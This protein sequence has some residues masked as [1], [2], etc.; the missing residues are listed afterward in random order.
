MHR[1]LC[2]NLQD[3]MSLVDSLYQIHRHTPL[4]LL[5]LVCNTLSFRRAF[6][7]LLRNFWLN[8]SA[9]HMRHHTPSTTFSLISL[10]SAALIP[11]KFHY[12]HPSPQL[13]E[14]LRY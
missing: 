4:G 7:L 1:T 10:Q 3:E 5:V 12:S 13:P 11:A 9:G 6:V 14:L 8:S 2:W